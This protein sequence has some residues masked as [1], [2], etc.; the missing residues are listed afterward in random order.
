MKK[1]VSR[2]TFLAVSASA[3]AL[4]GSASADPEKA[5]PPKI[6]TRT[7]G[8]RTGLKVPIVSMGVGRADN[9][10]LIR[11]SLKAGVVHFDTAHGYQRGRSEEMLGEVLSKYPRDSFI[12]STKINPG[13]KRRGIFTK[14]EFLEQLD[15]SLERLHMD[16]VDILYLHSAKNA[17]YALDPV[18]LDALETA[19]QEGKARFIG[20]STHSSEPEVINA[21][22]DCGKYDVVL[23]AY[24]ITQKH[25][26]ELQQAM[27][28]AHDAGLGVVV[29]KTMCGRK[30][31]REGLE[32]NALAAM[33]WALQPEY[34]HTAIP[35][36]TTFDQM[37]E[38]VSV[39]SDLKLTPD[40]IED[41]KE[42]AA[43]PEM[44][45]CDGCGLCQKL[46]RRNL[47]LPDLMRSY[48]Y[49]YGY[50]APAQAK[51]TVVSTEVDAHPCDGCDNCP[52]RCPK[53]YDVAAR[54]TDIAR[55][56]ET[57]DEFLV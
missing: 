25:A 29:M 17:D 10:A 4:A 12:I 3:G 43:D 5:P 40:E 27:K 56:K 47:P 21:A 37:E 24:N 55:I 6:I 34:A 26:K 48:M 13:K 2:R 49:N 38:N 51:E 28:R 15:I 54:I 14:E 1:P 22:V 35:G 8:K 42:I 53:G 16:Y 30:R 31:R 20:V 32:V 52:V 36:Y 7:L 18:Y 44:L 19:K 45:Y 23:T 46:C 41:L 9:P 39:L 33:K 57:P 11:A 50:D